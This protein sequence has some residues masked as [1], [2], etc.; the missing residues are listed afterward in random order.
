MVRPLCLLISFSVLFAA[1]P[2]RP[3]IGLAL[4]GGSALGLAHVGVIKWLEENRVPID[5]IAGASMGSLVGALYATGRTSAEIEEFVNKLDWATALQPDTP[6]RQLAFRRKE[7]RREFP[8]RLEI[9]LK[10]GKLRLPAALSA[11]H[12]VGLV[13]SRIAAGYSNLRSFDD[14]PTPFRC[15]ATDLNSA[16]EIEFSSGDLFDALRASMSLPGLFAP[17]KRSDQMLVDGGIVNNLPVNVVKG[18]GAEIVIAV[19]LHVP[20]AQR[21]QQYSMFG[22]FDRTL[23]IMLSGSELRSLAAAEVALIPDLASFGSG[24]FQRSKEFIERG[25][26]AAAGKANLLKRFA[27]PEAEWEAYRKAR[28]A[29]RRHEIFEPEFV[30]SEGLNGPLEKNLANRLAD[31]LTPLSTVKPLDDELT[32]LIGLGRWDTASYRIIEKD[33]KQGL[34]VKAQEKPHGPPF[35]NTSILIDGGT[36]QT[37]RFGIG[38]R[39]T[40]LDVLRPGSEWRTDFVIGFR[41]TLATEYFHRVKSTKFFVAPRAFVEKYQLDVYDRNDRVAQFDTRETGAALDLGY[42]AGRFSEFRLGYQLSRFTN[43]VSIG[44]PSL[45]SLHGNVS[46]MR[47][48]WAHEGQDNPVVATKGVRWTTNAQWI[49]S[50]PGNGKNGF[51]ILE[52]DLRWARP[53]NSRYSLTGQF[54]GGTTANSTN[55]FSPFNLGGPLR[56]SALAPQQF[57]GSHYYLSSVGVLWAL[58]EKPTQYFTRLYLT[59]GYELG[60]AFNQGGRYKPYHDGVAGLVGQTP[61]GVVFVGGAYGEQGQRKIFVR[62]G[63]YF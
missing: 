27:L 62:L 45:P 33:G 47:A 37:S 58:S 21:A 18:M 32:R 56:L 48:R 6:F 14:L 39:L 28:Q 34:L 54:A 43:S 8:N 5:A 53:V 57:F 51:P 17:L 36:S 40:F 35:L 7:D 9:G 44:V 22:V 13:I 26:Q 4:A 25:Y 46:R 11:G 41:D 61:F 38:G 12:G 19:A 3:K 20:L 10:G 55:L 2:D 29:R 42:A 1:P 15:V 24:D 50:A 16:K 63:R 31:A 59:A 60:S 49:F 52:A 30:I 23:D